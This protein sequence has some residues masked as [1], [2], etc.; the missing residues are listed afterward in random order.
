MHDI[1]L[2]GLLG[3]I[4]PSILIAAFS[5]GISFLALTPPMPVLRA[6]LSVFVG[7]TFSVYTSPV[8]IHIT[9]PPEW[10]H[11]CIIYITGAIGVKILPVV[12]DSVEKVISKGLVERIAKYLKDKGD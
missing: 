11:N 10:A 9:G 8:V 2:Y 5:G 3:E 1:E 12:S 4:K 6:I 7:L